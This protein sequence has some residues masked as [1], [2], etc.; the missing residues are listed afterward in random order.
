M[1][2]GKKEE[3]KIRRIIIDTDGTNIVISKSEVSNLEM[4]AILSTILNK[5]KIQ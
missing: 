2:E 1:A 4:F 5:L 3:S